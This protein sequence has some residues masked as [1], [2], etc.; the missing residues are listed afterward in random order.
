MGALQISE[1]PTKLDDVIGNKSTIESIKGILNRDDKDIPQAWLFQ[2]PPGCGKTTLA[3]IIKEMLE[4]KD[5]NFHEY[6]SASMR[7]IDTIRDISRNAT[8]SP[9]GGGKQAYLIDECHQITGPAQEALLKTL[10]DVPPNTWFFLATTNP[11]KLR[12]AIKS[13]CTLISVDRVGTKDLK[14]LINR[15]LKSLGLKEI[16][17]TVEKQIIK[18]ANGA[19][20]DAIKLLDTIIDI[21]NEDDMLNAVNSAYV[22]ETTVKDIWTIL[23]GKGK[24][25]QKWKEL[26]KVLKNISGEPEQMRYALLT[27][28]S[29]NLLDTGSVK[30]A[31]MIEAFENNYY[32]SGHAGLILSCFNA[33][34]IE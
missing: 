10:E 31:G 34:F 30:T 13:R 1:R 4:I 6:N 7:G 26:A 14:K 32:D 29:R 19:C 24:P 25:A 27:V 28:L 11:E 23:L 12:P 3:R 8:A 21:N 2:G 18:N 20:R 15:T 5:L 9:L 22:D 17:K 16:P 33:C